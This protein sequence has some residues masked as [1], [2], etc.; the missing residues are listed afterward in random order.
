MKPQSKL[1]DPKM[2]LLISKLLVKNTRRMFVAISVTSFVL[3]IASPSIACEG[4]LL[5]D[6]VSFLTLAKF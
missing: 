1:I 3:S 6:V 4:M 5:V 2:R